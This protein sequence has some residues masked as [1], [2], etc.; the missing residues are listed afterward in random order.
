MRNKIKG[1]FLTG[2]VGDAWGF[3]IE[4]WPP[5]RTEAMYPGGVHRYVAPVGHKWFNPEEHPAGSTTDDAQFT[6]ATMTGLINGKDEAERTGSYEPYMDAIAK[7]HVESLATSDAG[8]GPSTKEAIWRLAAGVSWKESGITTEEKRGTGNGVP[9][10]AAALAMWAVTPVGQ[11]F[12]KKIPFNQFLADFGAMTH[13]TKMGT[14]AGVIHAQCVK[15]CL[16]TS[17]ESFSASHVLDIM[18]DHCWWTEELLQEGLKS[19]FVYDISRLADTTDKLI[20]VI[21]ILEQVSVAE[22]LTRDDIR[23]VFGN[24]LCYVYHSLPFAYAFFLRHPESIQ[25][26]DDVV[27]AGGD[28]DT[29]GKIVGDLVGALHGVELLQT[30]ENIWTLKGLREYEALN[31]FVDRF[32]DIFGVD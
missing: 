12:I 7:A 13:G 10:K 31:S 20:D 14:Q 5:E 16:E 25:C 1:C 3:P 17:P 30:P 22:R 6:V 21:R 26:L 4:M 18:G 32:C 28:T 15:Y 27:N 8:S 2:C 29:N 24:G 11:D 9:M 19:P 23:K